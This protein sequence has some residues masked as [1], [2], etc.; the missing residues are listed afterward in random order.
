MILG[1]IIIESVIEI[2]FRCW[3]EIYQL[4]LYPLL[5]RLFNLFSCLLNR[6]SVCLPAC[7]QIPSSGRYQD[8]M[9]K[10]RV[11]QPAAAASFS[12]T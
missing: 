10:I 7:E 2:N 12:T 6:P 1:I 8:L 9:D 11:G 4:F 3:W 5:L